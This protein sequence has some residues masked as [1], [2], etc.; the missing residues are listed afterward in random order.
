MYIQRTFIMDSASQFL[1]LYL[2]FIKGVLDS[3]DLPLNV[4]R[5]IL[6]GSPAVDSIRSALVKRVLDMLE[7]MAKESPDDY[8][9]F[10][11]EFGAVLKEGPAEDFAN[12]ERIGGLFRYS[13][14]KTEGDVPSASFADYISRMKEDQDKIYYLVADS[15]TAARNSAYLEIFQ[16]QGIEVLLLTERL[17]EWTLSHLYEFDGKQ[18]QDITKGELDESVLG[19]TEKDDETDSE[20]ASNVMEKITTCLNGRVDSVRETRR[21]TDSPACLVYAEHALSPQ[22]RKMMR[23]PQVSPFLKISLCWK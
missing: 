22:M 18:L 15:L 17:D 2:R 11:T 10:W 13:S 14:T 4:S 6:Q 12:R 8:T 21:L 1:P 20:S 5:E 19:K 9:I 3:S 23:R 16:K 7:K